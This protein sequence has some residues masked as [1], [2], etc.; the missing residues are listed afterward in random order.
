LSTHSASEHDAAV[1]DR[2]GLGQR[3]VRVHRADARAEQHEISR[4]VIG[5]T[6]DEQESAG[7]EQ[8]WCA[9]AC[10]HDRYPAVDAR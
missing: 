3:T 5:P 2:N 9:A 6:S 8:P 10:G 4:A 1:A 7:D